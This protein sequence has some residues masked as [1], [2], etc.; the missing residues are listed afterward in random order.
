M[1]SKR[2][3]GLKLRVLSQ[4]V[5]GCMRAPK[6]LYV[7]EHQG[8][9]QQMRA[10]ERPKGAWELESAETSSNSGVEDDTNLEVKP[11]DSVTRRGRRQDGK[12]FPGEMIRP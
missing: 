6:E 1:V 9:A 4:C 8:H 2:F 3:R 5:P 11:L 12:E 7:H 10:L